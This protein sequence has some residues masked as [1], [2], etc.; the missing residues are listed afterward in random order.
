LI[1]EQQRRWRSRPFHQLRAAFD[2]YS[3]ALSRV[4][5]VGIVTSATLLGFIVAPTILLLRGD[6]WPSLASFIAAIAAASI[7]TTAS[8]ILLIS[9]WRAGVGSKCAAA[10]FGAVGDELRARREAEAAV[11]ALSD[12]QLVALVDAFGGRRASTAHG[13]VKAALEGI[14]TRRLQSAARTEAEPGPAAAVCLAALV[15]WLLLAAVV[16]G[17]FLGGATGDATAIVLFVTFG[18][19]YGCLV[20]LGGALCRRAEGLLQQQGSSA[21]A[22]AAAVP[23]VLSLSFAAATAAASAAAGGDVVDTWGA[24]DAIISQDRAA[25]G[26]STRRRALCGLAYILALDGAGQAED[27]D[28]ADE[29]DGV[30]KVSASF[31]PLADDWELALEK[32]AAFAQRGLNV[33]PTST[34][35]HQTP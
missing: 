4:A 11:S 31:A 20:P 7:S 35:R 14:A 2:G 34:T 17:F 29:L 25:A 10:A 15:V 24:A 33:A 23:A 19:T 9:L 3:P 30:H 12:S 18:A 28:G 27:P 16:R 1:L 26:V 32:S 8:Y 21:D 6:G 13:D 22:A 5:H